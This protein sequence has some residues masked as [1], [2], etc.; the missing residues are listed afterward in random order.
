MPILGTCGGFQYM[1]VEFAR[2]VAG[3]AGAGHEEVDPDTEDIVVG[4]LAC[5]LVGEERVV[6]A[7]PGT[8]L[9]ALCGIEP[10]VRLP[11]LQLRA[12]R[13][14]AGPARGGGT[15]AGRH[16]RGRGCRG[17]RAARAPVLPR[18]P[19]PA[20][21]SEAQRGGPCT[22]CWALWSTPVVRGLP[23]G[24]PRSRYAVGGCVP[25]GWTG[26]GGQARDDMEVER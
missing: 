8:R 10:F 25:D 12:A 6:T 18:H 15:R 24:F 14:P 1:A 7:L 22:R 2:N 26:P 21:R 5:S 9:A 4:R 19:L 16:R 20:R 23:S 11:L 17:V 13:R 3:I